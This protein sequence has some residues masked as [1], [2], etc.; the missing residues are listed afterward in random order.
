MDFTEYFGEVISVYTD[1]QG[2]E[3]GVL[4]DISQLG[5]RFKG[6]VI[7]RMT[8]TLWADFESFF[9]TDEG[10]NLEALADTLRTK[11]S[12]ATNPGGIWVLPPKLWLIE[13][14]VGGWTLMHPEDY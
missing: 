6:M 2:L 7:N 11:C 13:N 8:Q 12:M 5:V 14:E 1:A 4:V 10:M 3:D 9:K